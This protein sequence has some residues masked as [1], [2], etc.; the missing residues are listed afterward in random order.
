MVAHYKT[1]FQGRIDGTV[2]K[3]VQETC[4]I[5]ICL[6]EV[7]TLCSTLSHFHSFS[8][9]TLRHGGRSQCKLN[10]NYLVIEL[11]NK[12]RKFVVYK[13]S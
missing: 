4:K 13:V 9:I 11:R 7:R 10:Y 3:K 12:V 1:L 6:R 8:K 5:G 2:G